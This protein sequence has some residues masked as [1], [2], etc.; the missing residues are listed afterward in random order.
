MWRTFGL[1]HRD[2]KAMFPPFLLTLTN[3]GFQMG[4]RKR[5]WRMRGSVSLPRSIGESNHCLCFTIQYLPF[6][7]SPSSFSIK[8]FFIW[9]CQKGAICWQTVVSAIPASLFALDPRKKKMQPLAALHSL[10]NTLPLP[11]SRK[12]WLHGRA[13][14]AADPELKDLNAISLFPT[15]YF[16]LAFPLSSYT[17]SW[18]VELLLNAFRG[19][20][21]MCLLYP[22]CYSDNKKVPLLSCRWK[23]YLDLN[24][25]H[26]DSCHCC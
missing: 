20:H 1:T 12:V 23:L 7:Y 13:F 9:R 26:I 11:H 3:N 10:L 14:S 18:A 25:I 17:V 24:G 16:K 22:Y 19:I 5:L 2:Y 21:F 8:S 4:E 6:M 15:F